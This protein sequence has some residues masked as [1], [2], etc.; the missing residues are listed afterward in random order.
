MVYIYVGDLNNSTLIICYALTLGGKPRAR[1]YLSE[2]R[3]PTGSHYYG[4]RDTF[5]KKQGKSCSH[6]I[7]NCMWLTS[8]LK[9]VKQYD[10]SFANNRSTVVPAPKH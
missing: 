1:S 3:K 5:Q 8:C 10:S 2:Y 7:I 9:E 4:G 6:H